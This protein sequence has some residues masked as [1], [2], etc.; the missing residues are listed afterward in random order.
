MCM[1]YALDQHTFPIRPNRFLFRCR[2]RFPFRCRIRIFLR[3]LTNCF[4]QL[5]VYMLVCAV[6]LYAVVLQ[7]AERSRAST[8]MR[9]RLFTENFAVSFYLWLMAFDLID[10]L[11]IHESNYSCF[12]H[13]F[14]KVFYGWW[15]FDTDAP[16]K[17]FIVYFQTNWN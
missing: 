7:L 11:E 5:N 3:Q 15:S 16:P 2:F 4:I 9:N 14:P 8:K 12:K 17:R 13:C 1:F 10:S 6:L